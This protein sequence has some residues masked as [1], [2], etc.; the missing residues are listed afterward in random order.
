MKYAM[1]THIRLQALALLGSL[2]L[3]QS[4]LVAPAQGS[5]IRGLE[6]DKV[7]ADAELI[8]EGRVIDHQVRRD[9]RSGLIHTYVTFQ[10]ID[11][12]KGSPVGDTLELRFSGGMLDGELVE[13]SGLVIPARGEAGI[14]FVESLSRNLLNPLL[15]W[16]QGHY[17]IAEVGRQRQVMSLSGSPVIDVQPMAAVPS[18]IK[19]ALGNVDGAH[20]AAQGV[21]LDS[22]TVYS[23]LSSSTALSVEEFKS[24]I[25]ALIE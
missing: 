2:L 23:A 10:V 5:T 3:I 17:V 16:S 13:V 15:G 18:S 8:F 22:G 12:I 21:V 25:R 6:I 9:D 7:A 14:Y 11:V 19:Q 1:P 4:I 20:A 24:R